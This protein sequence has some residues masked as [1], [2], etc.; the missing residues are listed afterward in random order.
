[1]TEYLIQ[2]TS[3]I[4]IGEQIREMN[5]VEET[6]SPNGMAQTLIDANLKIATQTALIEQISTALEGK[7]VSSTPTI[8][9]EE[10]EKFYSNELTIRVS[11]N[12]VTAIYGALVNQ[13]GVLAAPVYVSSIVGNTVISN[14]GSSDVFTK[15]FDYSYN[16]IEIPYELCGTYK[17]I[18][19]NDASKSAIIEF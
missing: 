3:L 18:V 17:F 1:M 13:G 8:E 14:S 16:A 4:A 7:C 10:I 11:L 9:Y 6:Y 19:I 12:R 5:D 2:D 15:A